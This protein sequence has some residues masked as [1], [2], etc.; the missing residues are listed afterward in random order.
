LL[1]KA[2]RLLHPKFHYKNIYKCVEILL[3]NGYPLIF[4][5]KINKRVKSLAVTIN[6]KNR[7]HGDDGN[8]VSHVDNNKGNFMVLSYVKN[9]I[10]SLKT[11]IKNTKVRLSM[12]EPIRLD[13]KGKLKKEE[14]SDVLQNLL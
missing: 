12:L 9:I 13:Y 11:C 5:H 2:V 6:Y 14:N 7:N 4:H 3:D 8:K 10:D 1:D